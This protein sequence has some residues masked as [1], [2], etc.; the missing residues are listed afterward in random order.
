MFHSE[1][2]H[3]ATIAEMKQ[4][5][6]WV[7]QKCQNIYTKF[8]E[9]LFIY[10]QEIFSWGCPVLSIQAEPKNQVSVLN[11]SNFK[12][13]LSWKLYLKTEKI[14]C[15]KLL[16]LKAAQI[17][18]TFIHFHDYPNYFNELKCH[19][20]LLFLLQIT[21]QPQ[22]YPSTQLLCIRILEYS[23]KGGKFEKC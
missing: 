23:E 11:R 12:C 22:R 7:S 1:T 10:T 2:A 6:R 4:C 20:A 5:I 13:C 15:K 21:S 14:L 3:P 19:P 8:F 9:V 17:L 16:F 18:L